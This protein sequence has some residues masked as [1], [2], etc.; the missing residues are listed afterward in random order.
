[1]L[2]ARIKKFHPLTDE[3]IMCSLDLCPHLYWLSAGPAISS[4]LRAQHTHRD[5]NRSYQ[6]A[7]NLLLQLRQL[8]QSSVTAAHHEGSGQRTSPSQGVVII[9][10]ISREVFTQKMWQGS[11]GSWRNPDCS[12]AETRARNDQPWGS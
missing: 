7:A 11:A 9:C 8:A 4:Q 12:R 1:M 3:S 2:L 5:K 6:G 10:R